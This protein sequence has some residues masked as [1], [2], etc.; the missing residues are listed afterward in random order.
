[1]SEGRVEALYNR[2]K[3]RAVNFDFRPG[4]RIN[5]GTIARQLDASRT[6]L[7]EAL[8]RLVAERLIEFRPGQGFFCRALDP[9]TIFELYEMRVVIE[10]AA[11]RRACHR[12]EGAGIAALRDRLHADGLTTAGLTIREVVERD[13]AFHLGIARLAGNSEMVRHLDRIN[14][15]IRFIRW[16]DMG[17]RVGT[18]KGEHLEIMEALEARDED[19][20]VAVL[21]IHVMRRMDQIVAAVREGYSNIFVSDP[22][23]LFDRLVGGAE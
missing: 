7:R 3:E 15:R 14:E 22:E 13:E 4:E 6:P 9:Q 16:V 8:N 12:A 19:R 21:E 23:E 11:V 20:A 17:H 2:L 18:T 10:T 5:E 1:M